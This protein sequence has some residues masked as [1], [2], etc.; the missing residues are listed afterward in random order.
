MDS[1]VRSSA[2]GRTNVAMLTLLA[3]WA[4]A[5]G[6]CGGT[7]Q[8][9]PAAPGASAGNDAGADEQTSPAQAAS[10]HHHRDWWC[11]E[12][13]VPEKECGQCDARLVQRFQSQG[14]WCEQHERPDSQCFL[15]HPEYARRFAARYEARFGEPPPPHAEETRP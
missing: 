12:H 10:G 9:P 8:A 14:D 15:C 1:R 11:T 4:C 13:G 5:V 7:A 2:G 6:G 3:G